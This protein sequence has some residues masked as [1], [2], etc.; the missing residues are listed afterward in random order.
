[1]KTSTTDILAAAA[2]PLTVAELIDGLAASLAAWAVGEGYIQDAL[3]GGW[4]PA[5]YEL[6]AGDL[7]YLR[8]KQG[9]T[10]GLDLPLSDEEAQAELEH[11]VESRLR[12]L[13][14]EA[15]ETARAA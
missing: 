12:E 2:A 3:A 5:R 13:L 8:G 4:D 7:E 15:V 1:M 9:G 14:A 11:L 10:D 6:L